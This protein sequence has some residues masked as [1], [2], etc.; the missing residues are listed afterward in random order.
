MA[1]SGSVY[2]ESKE[3]RLGCR[4]PFFDKG[5]FINLKPTASRHAVKVPKFKSFLSS[6]SEQQQMGRSLTENVARHLMEKRHFKKAGGPQRHLAAA[7]A[8]NKRNR[9][10]SSS[11]S[12]IQELKKKAK[13][14]KVTPAI[15][16]DEWDKVLS[17][18]SVKGASL[19]RHLRSRS[20]YYVL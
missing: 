11:L 4:F 19:P 3:Q 16:V 10:R 9:R 8:V 15:V 14:L 2:D 12:R 7:R 20:R 5:I 1:Q 6:E 17:R 18:K 13:P